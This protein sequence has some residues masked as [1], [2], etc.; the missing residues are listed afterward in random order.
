MPKL[1]WVLLPLAAALAWWAIRAWRGRPPT[2]QA[3]NVLFSLLLLG[4]V[5]GTAGLGIFWVANQQLPVFDWHYLFG[6]STVLVLLVHLGFNLRVVWQ[7]LR[8]GARPA[9]SPT[10]ASATKPPAGTRRPLI[11]AAGLAA[12]ASAAGL[13]YFVGLRH[14]R[15]ELQ[16]SAAPREGT[17]NDIAAQRAWAVVERFHAFSSHSR[18]RVLRHAAS[19]EWGN[20]P[21][22]FK[23]YEGTTRVAFAAPSAAATAA[24]ATGGATAALDLPRLGVALWHAA[25]IS[26][27]RGGLALRTSPSSGALFATELYVLA[28][29]VPGV[30]AG[31]WHYAAEAHALH[32]LPASLAA[33]APG[34]DSASL[35]AAIGP[36]A[37]SPRCA[38]LVVASAVF[39]RSGHKYGDRTYRYV[40]A[41]L[42]H[43][44]ENLRVATAAAG[45]GEVQ[46]LAAFDDIAIGRALGLEARH[47]GVLAVAA[48]TVGSAGAGTAAEAPVSAPIRWTD[49]LPEGDGDTRLGLTEA[50]HASTSLRARLGPP[51]PSPAPAVPLAT[52]V[53]LAVHTLPPARSLASDPLPLIA[54]RRSHRRF[55]AQPVT[56]EA[57]AA[58][59]RAMTAPAPLLSPAVRID[60]LTTAVE[61]MP[62]AAWRV[63]SDD[64][65][66]A[67]LTLHRRT[68][69]SAPAPLRQRARA[70]A[71]DQD[72]IGDAAVVFVLSL[73]RAALLAD[74]AGAARGYRHGFLEAGLVGERIYLAAGAL[75]LATCAVGAFYDDEAAAL[76][77]LDAEREW[78]VHFAALGVRG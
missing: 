17:G 59:L 43:L 7:Q 45:G 22:S 15:T 26:E 14:G 25:G 58:V 65:H 76:V 20:A 66:A 72:V 46:L 29:E 13:G 21:P 32:R 34:L 4:Y 42:G 50:M 73:D 56:R 8:R 27:R 51:M 49:A 60:V 35:R 52:A 5:A 31:A 19:G 33:A 1:L 37:L 2:R 44:L 55:S 41:D 71:L 68:P 9:A 30:A 67:A 64:A 40:L 18:T 78:P 57:L 77:G 47:E 54:R 10:A 74:A 70:A 75:G 36:L 12:L 3:L 28:L 16:I 53:P 24:P 69:S 38:A 11:G 39:A 23:R 48:I 63:A 61:A 6:Y 62:A